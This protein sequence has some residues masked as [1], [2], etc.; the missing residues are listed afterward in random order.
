MLRVSKQIQNFEDLFD[1]AGDGSL[2][3]TGTEQPPSVDGAHPGRG[4]D[5]GDDRVEKP[6]VLCVCVRAA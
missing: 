5:I 1:G 6:L 3:A 2:V 4:W